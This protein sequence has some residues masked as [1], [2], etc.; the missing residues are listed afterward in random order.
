M[1]LCAEDVFAEE[2]VSSMDEKEKKKSE[3]KRY[4][5]G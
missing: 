1:L 3:E 5:D 2:K 4:E